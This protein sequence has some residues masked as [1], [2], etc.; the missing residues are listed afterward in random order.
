MLVPAP[1]AL[2]WPNPVWGPVRVGAH[3]AHRALMGPYG[4]DF[5]KRIIN[6]IENHENINKNI[7]GMKSEKIKVK[8]WF[9]DKDLSSFDSIIYETHKGNYMEHI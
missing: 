5:A 3:M 4:P 7:K 8:T 1:V 6:L 9:C 2:L